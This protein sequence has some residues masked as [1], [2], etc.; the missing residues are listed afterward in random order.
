[1]PF[2]RRPA[3]IDTDVGPESSNVLVGASDE[4]G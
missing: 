3:I 2:K 4:E 1:M